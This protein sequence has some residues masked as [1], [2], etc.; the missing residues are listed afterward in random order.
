MKILKQNL[1]SQNHTEKF[2]RSVFF[3][4]AFLSSGYLFSQKQTKDDL[5]QEKIRVDKEIKKTNKKLD[6]EKEKK[7]SALVDLEKSQYKIENQKKK[8]YDLDVELKNIEISINESK[9]RIENSTKSIELNKIELRSIKEQYS[10]LIYQ[11]YLWKNTY[12]ESYFL[13]SSENLNQLYKRNKFLEELIFARSK[14]IILIQKKTRQIESEQ[15]KLISNKDTLILEKII[16]E[17]IV[18]EQEN[19]KDNLEN[20]KTR[21]LEIINVI[22]KNEKF[23][24][25]LISEKIQ[26]SKDIESQIKKI[27]EEEIRISRENARKN[28]T[29]SPLTP[30]YLELSNNFTNNKGKLPW[31]LEKGVIIGRYGKQKH[32]AL[33]GVEIINNGI[34]ISTDLGQDIR[35]VFD[36]SVS[37]IFFIKGKGKAVLINHGEYFT[38]YSALQDVIVKTGEKVFAKQKIGTIAKNQ[39]D[40]YPKL[41]FEIWKDKETQ[42]PSK[43]LYKA[44]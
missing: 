2:I 18:R 5:N 30:E 34:D 35:S 32:P 27:I 36:G 16:Q 43:W 19:E 42:N 20:E 41:H 26:E 11:S 37:R 6:K 39:E 22:K 12:N 28:P 21:N 4:V 33:S 13:L 15:K 31:P 7:E 9:K 14:R 25:D 3:I 8:L 40:L 29:E 23:Y 1:I 17:K 10:K 24:Q 38:V 44:Y